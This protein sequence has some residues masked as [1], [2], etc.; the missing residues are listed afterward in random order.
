MSNYCYLLSPKTVLKH[1]IDMGRFATCN[2]AF[3]WVQ[4]QCIVLI[5]MGAG[6]RGN[7]LLCCTV[8]TAAPGPATT[9][10]NSP[11]LT[12]STST[13]HIRHQAD[14]TQHRSKAIS[15]FYHIMSHTWPHIQVFYLSLSSTDC[16]STIWR[17]F[18]I[19]SPLL[20]YTRPNDWIARWSLNYHRRSSLSVPNLCSF[21]LRIWYQY[22][23]VFLVSGV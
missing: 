5:M 14:Q 1:Q 19:G 15:C 22:E 12:P 9:S 21:N 18:E 4:W 17:Q 23:T 16:K 10:H 8:G 3:K 6:W 7:D 13:R 20:I 11:P 2:L